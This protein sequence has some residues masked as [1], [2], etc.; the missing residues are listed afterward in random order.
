MLKR[1][2][3]KWMGVTDIKFYKYQTPK[4]IVVHLELVAA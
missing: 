2:E 1:N 3:K 4:Y